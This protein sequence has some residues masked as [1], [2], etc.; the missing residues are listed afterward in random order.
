MRLLGLERAHRAQAGELGEPLV[1]LDPGAE[2]VDLWRV[3]R[4]AR[5]DRVLA[6]DAEARVE[7][8][9]RP[10]AVVREQEH[11]L[12]VLVEPAHRVEPRALGDEGRRQ[13][14][15]HRALGVTV[16]RRGG[17]AA[18]LVEQQVGVRR[19]AA[20]DAAVDRDDG[21]RR[22]PPASPSAATLPSTVTRPSAMS[23][24][25]ARREATP[26]AAST[27]WSRSAGISRARRRRASGV[28]GVSRRR[29]V[30]SPVVAV[31]RLAAL[32]REPAPRPRRRAAAAP[33]G[34]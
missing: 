2:R 18:R 5:R 4:G 21:L 3:E 14:V 11:P 20:D 23:V 17:D 26:A 24:S 30:A 7:H 32:L 10:R 19:R 22:D 33:R 9:L 15:E 29:S 27:F 28:D 1:E 13:Q 8:A 25:L 12:G 16:A 31:R 6:L 34:S